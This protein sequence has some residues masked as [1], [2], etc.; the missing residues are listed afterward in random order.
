MTENNFEMDERTS[1]NKRQ[2]NIDN[3]D[4]WVDTQFVM[5]QKVGAGTLIFVALVTFTPLKL[6]LSLISNSYYFSCFRRVKNSFM[7]QIR[8][9][10]FSCRKI[11]H[12]PGSFGRVYRAYAR[13]D[14]TRRPVAVKIMPI[15]QSD[16]HIALEL[17]ILRDIG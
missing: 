12:V 10:N 4:H 9:P 1:S 8:V 15:L 2:I 14:P 17:R 16:E 13:T 7:S 3:D 11:N 6:R 5:E